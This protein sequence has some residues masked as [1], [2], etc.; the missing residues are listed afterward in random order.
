LFALQANL[1]RKP[2]VPLF[3]S[4]ALDRVSLR[5]PVCF[6]QLD[7]P[8]GLTSTTLPDVDLHVD[9]LPAN[10]RNPPT[11]HRAKLHDRRGPAGSVVVGEGGNEVGRVK[12]VVS[13][14]REGLFPH[15]YNVTCQRSA[16]KK[17]VYLSPMPMGY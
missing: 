7:H 9:V 11:D 2:S 15:T 17:I 14:E 8:A 12:H 5:Q 10:M 3:H 1:T 6:G 13:E 16:V 4:P